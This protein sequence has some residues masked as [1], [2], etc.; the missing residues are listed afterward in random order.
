MVVVIML[1]VDGN[2]DR[3][4]GHGRHK[5]TEWMPVPTIV[6]WRVAVVTIRMVTTMTVVVAVGMMTVDPYV[7]AVINI[8]VDVVIATLVNFVAGVFS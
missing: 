8:D 4:N 2:N 7:F 3:R 6:K 5:E 1:I